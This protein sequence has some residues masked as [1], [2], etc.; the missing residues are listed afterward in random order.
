MGILDDTM[1]GEA[2]I[3]GTAGRHVVDALNEAASLRAQRDDLLSTIEDL[4]TASPSLNA[5]TREAMRLAWFPAFDRENKALNAASREA[6]GLLRAGLFSHGTSGEAMDSA[7]T[8]ELATLAR[9]AIQGQRRQLDAKDGS[10]A[11]LE[12]TVRELRARPLSAGERSE[13]ERMKRH[14]DDGRDGGEF[15]RHRDSMG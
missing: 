15:S 10:I 11:S 2:A 13:Y 6:R 14:F 4:R 1:G 3:R 7:S 12:A 9:D 5:E 8:I